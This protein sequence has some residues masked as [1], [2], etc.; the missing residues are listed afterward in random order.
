MSL[1]CRTAAA[2]EHRQDQ[3]TSQKADCSVIPLD[4]TS[5]SSIAFPHL[6]AEFPAHP[7][8]H[9]APRWGCQESS[10][11]QSSTWAE[12]CVQHLYKLSAT[13]HE[14]ITGQWHSARNEPEVVS[15]FLLSDTLPGVWG[16]R[17]PFQLITVCAS[18][19]LWQFRAIQ[20]LLLNSFSAHT[21]K[22]EAPVSRRISLV[23]SSRLKELLE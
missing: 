22:Q 16:Q 23:R 9:R 8:C 10:A 21:K 12:G 11:V 4:A 6:A 15:C 1:R 19:G 18:T 3:H 5:Q 17:K 20:F 2:V 7:P 14:R 13:T